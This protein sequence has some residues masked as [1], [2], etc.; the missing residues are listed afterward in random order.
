MLPRTISRQ[1]I[2]TGTL[3]P[4][5]RP[6]RSS[7]TR[8]AILQLQSKRNPIYSLL[9]SPSS[10]SSLGPRYRLARGSQR[11]LHSTRSAQKGLL[12]DS[13][14]PKPPNPQSSRTA[15]GGAIHVAE[16]SPLTDTEFHE[17]SEHYFNVLLTELERVQEEGSDKEAEYSVRQAKSSCYYL[18]S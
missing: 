6:P 17:N 1:S 5:P 15:A 14:N 16:P 10:P 18:A 13:P 4:H 11:N 9:S 12:P 3:L 2:T 7:S 8:L